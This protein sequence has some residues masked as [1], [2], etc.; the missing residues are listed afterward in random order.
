MQGGSSITQ[1]LAKNLFL[2][3]ERTLSRKIKE[4]YLAFWLEGHL[5]KRQILQLYLDRMYMGGGTFGVQAAAQYY[6]GKSI[7][8][9]SLAEAAMLAG[10]F[11]APSKYAPNVNLPAAR[12]RAADILQNMVDAGYLTEGQIYGALH[13]PATPIARSRDAAPDWYLDWAYDEVRKLADAHKLG[14]DRVLTVRTALDPNLQKFA[15]TTIEDQLRQYGHSYHVDQSAMVILDPSNGAVR[16][17][18]GGRD[19]G[20]SQFTAPTDALRQPG[21]LQTFRLFDGVADRQIQA[22][23]H[24]R[25]RPGVPR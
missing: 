22:L 13:N 10:L 4:A 15:D 7:R 2:S 19:Y 9:V 11:K 5:T 12:A 24:R 6:F 3:N 17:I 1:Q 8:N 14:G 25:R 20:E 18:V 16:T 21:L 23:D